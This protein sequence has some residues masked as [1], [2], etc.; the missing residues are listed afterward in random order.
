RAAVGVLRANRGA[1]FVEFPTVLAQV[2]SP[3][4]VGHHVTKPAA[5]V[6]SAPTAL[7][8]PVDVD[9]TIEHATLQY[10]TYTLTNGTSWLL[11]TWALSGP[12]HGSKVTSG[13]TFAINVLAVAPR[14]VQLPRGS[15]VF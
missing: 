4:G 13:A 12:E 9:V 7:G 14:Y 1:I 3:H 8:P 5:T 2:S 6:R 10:D 15:I 11:A